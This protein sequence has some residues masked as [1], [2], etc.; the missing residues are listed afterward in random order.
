MI[1]PLI[2]RITN[3]PMV[4]FYAVGVAFLAGLVC[5][6]VP[7]WKYQGA[8]LDAVR[9]EYKGFVNTTRIIGEQAAK[10][11]EKKKA[12]DKLAK[13]QSDAEYASLL[14]TSHS[15]SEQLRKSRAGRRYV[16]PATA[17]SKNPDRACFNRAGLES[18]MGFIDAEG[19]RIVG[20]GNDSRLKLDISKRWAQ[21]LP[22]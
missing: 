12:A 19:S 20:E 11:V 21:H 18:T 1:A 8:R 15:L 13:E 5:G 2:T 3:N 4:L 9:A 10:E 14:D 16:P 17:P 6:A 22:Q 7:A